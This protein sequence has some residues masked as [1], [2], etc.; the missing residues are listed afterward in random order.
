MKAV[1]GYYFIVL[2]AVFLVGCGQE[3]DLFSRERTIFNLARY[4]LPEFLPAAQ[5]TNLFLQL[6]YSCCIL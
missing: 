3:E 1:K 5:N 2:I 6:K 4:V